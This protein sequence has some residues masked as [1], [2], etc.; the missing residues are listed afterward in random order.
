MTLAPG[1]RR[2]RRTGLLLRRQGHQPQD[3]ADGHVH[4][5]LAAGLLAAGAP[6]PGPLDPVLAQPPAG[7]RNSEGHL[8]HVSEFLRRRRRRP[9]GVRRQRGLAEPVRRLRGVRE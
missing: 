2:G 6:H 3:A 8:E 9:V 1:F 5:P 7:S 4:P